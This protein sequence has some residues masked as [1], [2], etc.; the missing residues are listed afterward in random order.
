MATRSPY[1]GIITKIMQSETKGQLKLSA[2]VCPCDEAVARLL[3]DP[4]YPARSHDV[5]TQI[6]KLGNRLVVVLVLDLLG[7]CA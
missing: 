7:F 2:T 5:L 3:A 1:E 4:S 6:Q